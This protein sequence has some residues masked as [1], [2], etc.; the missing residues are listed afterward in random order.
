MVLLLYYF[1]AWT[2]LGPK[3]AFDDGS[4]LPISVTTRSTPQPRPSSTPVVSSAAGSYPQVNYAAV[5]SSTPTILPSPAASNP[6][7]PSPW[8]AMGASAAAAAAAGLSSTHQGI[9]HQSPQGL[10]YNPAAAVAAAAYMT[11]GLPASQLGQGVA[12]Y[13]AG[14]LPQSQPALTP[15]Y[16]G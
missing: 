14:T 13:G 10:A 7:T 2:C 11:S 15:T 5:V 9:P 12:F 16:P 4:L 1:V 6:Q 8:A 3:L